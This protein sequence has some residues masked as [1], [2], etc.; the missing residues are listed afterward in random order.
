MRHEHVAEHEVDDCSRDAGL[1]GTP[2]EPGL[3]AGVGGQRDHDETDGMSP[4]R[5]MRKEAREHDSLDREPHE[6]AHYEH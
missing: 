4:G 6:D 5:I 1:D 3:P 2:K